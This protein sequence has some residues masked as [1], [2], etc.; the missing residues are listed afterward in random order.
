V[1]ILGSKFWAL[2]SL[3]QKLKKKFCRGAHGEMTA[4]NGLI[5]SRNKKEEAT[6]GVWQTD[7]HPDRQTDRVNC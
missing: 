3:N 5:P 6:E 4:K 1:Q 7:R 2:G